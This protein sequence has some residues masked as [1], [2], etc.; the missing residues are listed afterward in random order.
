MASA[1]RLLLMSASYI[2]IRRR[3][4]DGSVTCQTSHRRSIAEYLSTHRLPL[5]TGK[6]FLVSLP[7]VTFIERL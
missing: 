7:P 4:R 1:S 6:V 2:Q 3:A 5:Q